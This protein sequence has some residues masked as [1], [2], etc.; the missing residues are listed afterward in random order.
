MPGP[1]P[2]YLARLFGIVVV[3]GLEVVYYEPQFFLAGSCDAHFVS[4]FFEPLIGIHHLQRFG[5][6]TCDKQYFRN[7]HETPLKIFLIASN[8]GMFWNLRSTRIPY[9]KNALAAPQQAMQAF[10]ETSFSPALLFFRMIWLS[11]SCGW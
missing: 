9:R 3:P 5:C 4:F 10:S 7:C 8:I 11:W 1:R 6:V 2:S